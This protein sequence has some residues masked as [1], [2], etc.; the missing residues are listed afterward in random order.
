MSEDIRQLY[1]FS[2]Y[3]HYPHFTDGELMELREVAIA[4]LLMAGTVELLLSH[5]VV[6]A[7]VSISPLEWDSSH[8]GRPMAK[9]ELMCSPSADVISVSKI[10]QQA[11]KDYQQK[12]SCKHFSIEIDMDDYISLNACFCAGFEVLDFKRTYFTNRL[13]D[14]EEYKR[15]SS[16]IRPYSEKDREAV[17]ELFY[18]TEFST[19]FT[20]DKY[21]DNQL[22]QD[23]Y[24]LW[25]EN[26]LNTYPEKSNI[27]IY[28]R[29]GKVVACGAIGEK[30]LSSLG[31]NKTLR[32]GSVYAST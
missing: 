3:R 29:H 12:T 24:R 31:V 20:R 6:Q 11:V 2:Q 32:T 25:A 30:N 7:L 14:S 23:I 13:H 19:R 28:E 9:V 15:F 22:A 18:N 17:L 21:L 5:D 26:L 27:L 10:V 4:R 8:F 1:H 16:S